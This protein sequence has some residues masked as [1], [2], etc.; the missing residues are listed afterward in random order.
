MANCATLFVGLTVL[1]ITLLAL[2]QSKADCLLPS[3]RIGLPSLLCTYSPGFRPR[4]PYGFPRFPDS[5]QR[6]L[7]VWPDLLL[8]PRQSAVKVSPPVGYSD[9]QIGLRF[10]TVHCVVALRRR[11]RCAAGAALTTRTCVHSIARQPQQETRTSSLSLSLCL[12]P[13]IVSL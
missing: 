6:R 4:W 2:P 8:G 1:C 12:S 3:H 9:R 7:P 5:W 13:I 10:T 11:Q